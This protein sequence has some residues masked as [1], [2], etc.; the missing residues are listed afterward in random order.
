MLGEKPAHS[1]AARRWSASDVRDVA[2]LVGVAERGVDHVEV[3]PGGDEM[4]G[5]PAVVAADLQPALAPEG[6][7]VV[8]QQRRLVEREHADIGVAL[9]A[10][11]APPDVRGV[12]AQIGP[13]QTRRRR[14]LARLGNL[15]SRPG[16]VE[17]R[18]HIVAAQASGPE[19][20]RRPARRRRSRRDRRW[21]CLRSCRRYRAAAAAR[22]SGGL[23][24]R[25]R[26]RRKRHGSRASPW[27][28]RND[29]PRD[30]AGAAR[31]R[32]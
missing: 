30:G 3:E 23:R 13:L 31:A 5:R 1:R 25:R 20:L 22:Q 2:H 7:G 6:Q 16:S 10:Q 28:D 32:A 27:L 26:D 8:V 21:V 4:G 18:R 17:A 19:R 15:A 11:I 12:L 24:A 29:R 14:R 9:A